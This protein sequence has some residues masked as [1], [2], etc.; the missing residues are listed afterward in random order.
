MKKLYILRHAKSDYPNGVGDF[1]RPLNKRGFDACLLIGKYLNDNFIKPEVILSSSSKRTEQTINTIISAS[2]LAVK[3]QFI[4]KLYLATAGEILKEIAKVD[5]KINSIMIVAHNPGV[6]VLAKLL[7][8]SGK[9]ESL[10]LL[11]IKYSTA[12]LA[13]LN[14]NMLSWS[15]L[16]PSSGYLQEFI[17]P[18]NLKI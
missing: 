18:N 12:G 1:D 13:I 7:A 10:E 6:A 9:K 8:G 16:D 14:F 2:H 11:Q 3:P 4:D 15:I 5:D 17:I